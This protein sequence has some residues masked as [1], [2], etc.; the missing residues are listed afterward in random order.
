MFADQPFVPLPG[1]SNGHV[2]TLAAWARRRSYPGLPSLDV[3]FIR[4]SADTQVRADCYWQ[5]HRHDRSTLLGLHGLEGS[6]EAHYMQGVAHKAWR[7]GWNVVLLN[8]RNCG[9]T[10]HLTPGLYHSGLT[11]DPV[12]VLRTLMRDDR[13]T[14]FAIVGYSLG[15]NLTLK[16]AAELADSPDL[17]VYAVAAVSPTIDLAL[18][19]DAIGWRQNAL[20]QWNF[21]RNL[22]A[23]MR[24]KDAA[25]PGVYDLARLNAVRTIRAFDDAYTAPS[26]GFGT[27]ANY[28]ALNSARRTLASVRIPALVIAAADD[29]FVPASQFTDDD[30]RDNANV[31]MCLQQH[32]GH[33]GFIGRA[34][35]GHDGYW[36]ESAAVD[37]VTSHAVRS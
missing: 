10:E 9:D 15:G 3:R 13:L 20:Y 25:F 17:P 35:D 27:A 18:C 12:V 16:L 32:G 33:C 22:K 31:T 1:L 24:R 2:M 4:V 28:Y 14:S 6:S 34:A 8:Q 26:N 30:V 21:V 29:P 19:V 37:F 36:A 5:P 7:L 23:R 11:A